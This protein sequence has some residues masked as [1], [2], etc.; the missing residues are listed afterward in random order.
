MA[1]YA[2]GAAC[3]PVAERVCRELL[4]LPMHPCLSDGDVGR[5]VEGVRSFFGRAL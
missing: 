3:C 1:A 4:C 5:V 2:D